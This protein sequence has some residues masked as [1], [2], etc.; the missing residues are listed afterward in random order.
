ML[1]LGEPL[2]M[3]A[4]VVWWRFSHLH[5]FLWNNWTVG[6]VKYV[7]I[8]VQSRFLSFSRH[9]IN[10][11]GQVKWLP[12]PA[13]FKEEIMYMKGKIW[14]LT[15]D[16]FAEPIFVTSLSACQTKS[17]KWCWFTHQD[18]YWYVKKPV[19]HYI[20]KCFVYMVAWRDKGVCILPSNEYPLGLTK[21]QFLRIF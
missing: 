21:R 16:L 7:C 2:L 12:T 10:G 3:S 13:V 17:W 18:I 14:R 19:C 8:I 6:Y 15:H 11:A 20:I 1:A 4:R 5:L 9:Y